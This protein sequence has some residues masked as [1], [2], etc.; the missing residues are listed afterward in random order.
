[1]RFNLSLLHKWPRLQQ[2]VVLFV[3]LLT[4]GNMSVFGYGTR[5]LGRLFGYGQNRG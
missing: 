5:E 1:M 2:K 3:G 4:E